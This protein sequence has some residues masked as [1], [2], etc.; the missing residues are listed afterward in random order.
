LSGEDIPLGARIISVIDAYDAM[1]SDGP[2]RKALG[3][4]Y[5]ISEIKKGMGT[6]F[7]ILKLL[8]PS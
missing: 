4:E 3:Y 6:Q 8:K 2:Y 1:T 7:V 5:A